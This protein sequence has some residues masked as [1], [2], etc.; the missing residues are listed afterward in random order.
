MRAGEPAG[1]AI[2][3]SVN[4]AQH[5]EQWGYKRHW[6]AEHHSI[7]GLGLLGDASA[8]WACGGSDQDD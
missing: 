7:P 5:V 3:R 6:L 2:A 1:S 8:D 4:L